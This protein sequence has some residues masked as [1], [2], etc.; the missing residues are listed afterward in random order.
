MKRQIHDHEQVTADEKETR[1]K[2]HDFG[3]LSNQD[4]I[5]TFK[6]IY[7]NSINKDKEVNGG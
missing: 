4:Q 2:E 7:S 3:E 5:E 1:F 6:S